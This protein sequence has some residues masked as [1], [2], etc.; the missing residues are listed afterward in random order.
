[1]TSLASFAS[2]SPRWRTL[3]TGPAYVKKQGMILY[4]AET[5]ENFVA[6]KERTKTRDDDLGRKGERS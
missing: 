4:R 6:S 1:V 5:I 3:G 2:A